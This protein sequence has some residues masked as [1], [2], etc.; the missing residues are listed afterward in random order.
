MELQ[1]FDLLTSI[2]EPTW[3]SELHVFP[4]PTTDLLKISA[5]VSIEEIRLID[6]NGRILKSQQ[7][8]DLQQDLNMQDLPSGVYQLQLIN[9]KETVNRSI[10]K[11]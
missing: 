6:I 10:V 8:H 11:E 9:G 7:V 1:S 4:N 3:A 5:S 2:Q